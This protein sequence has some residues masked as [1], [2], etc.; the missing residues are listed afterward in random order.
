MAISWYGASARCRCSDR[1]SARGHREWRE[2]HRYRRFLWPPCHEPDHTKSAVTYR[3]RW[4]FRTAWI[5]IA[6][7]REVI[8]SGVNH[9][10]TADFYGPHVTNRI[11][12][13]A[14]SPTAP[15]G[16]LGLPGSRSL[17]C[18]RSSRVA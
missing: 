10:D 1:S 5:E 13:K 6:P 9:I 18:E 11:I 17:L 4:I 14:L 16:Y 15:A 8:A 12:R 2:P 3:A 7:L